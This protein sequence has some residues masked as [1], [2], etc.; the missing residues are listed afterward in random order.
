MTSNAQTLS[1]YSTIMF[2]IDTDL[3]FLA[4]KASTE[5][6]KCFLGKFLVK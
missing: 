3:I 6:A 5:I 1:I 2:I 4:K